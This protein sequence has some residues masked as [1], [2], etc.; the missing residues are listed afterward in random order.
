[1]L[2]HGGLRVNAEAWE[3]SDGISLILQAVL[4][5]MNLLSQALRVP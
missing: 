5:K 3:H 4:N 1:M 2:T